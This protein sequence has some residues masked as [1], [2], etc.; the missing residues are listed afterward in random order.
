MGTETYIMSGKSQLRDTATEE[1]TLH[2][3][4]LWYSVG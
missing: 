3:K 1:V 4:F 2:L